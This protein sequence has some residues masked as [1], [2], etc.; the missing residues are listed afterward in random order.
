[1]RQEQLVY[2]LYGASNTGKTTTLRLLAKKLETVALTK[3][4]IPTSGDFVAMFELKGSNIAIVSAG[5][6]KHVIKKGLEALGKI[7][8]YDILFCASRTRG[9]TTHFL[10]NTFKK[11]QLRWVTNMYIY[12]K[13]KEQAN[14]C[15]ESMSEFLFNSLLLE[16]RT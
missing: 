14:L 7:S 12:G 13:S 4:E 1:M 9:Q 2:A 10:T 8:R 15:N 11:Q 16:L 3:D 5:D 6:N